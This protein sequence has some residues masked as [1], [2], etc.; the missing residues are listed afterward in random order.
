MVYKPTYNWRAQP[1]RNPEE[2]P[3]VKI[4]GIGSFCHLCRGKETWWRI[5]CCWDAQGIPRNLSKFITSNFD[6]L[7]PQ[8]LMVNYKPCAIMLK[9]IQFHQ[10]WLTWLTYITWIW[11]LTKPFPTFHQ[12]FW[13]PAIISQP[14]GVAIAE[15][16]ACQVPRCDQAGNLYLVF[17]LPGF[18]HWHVHQ[19]SPIGLPMKSYENQ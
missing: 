10:D 4:H 8:I 11:R 6:L 12:A 14:K 19:I 15:Q 3:G 5:A 2:R 17:V 18:G 13:V 9:R 7:R 16:D 1:W